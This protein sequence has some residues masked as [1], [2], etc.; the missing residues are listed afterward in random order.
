MA[1]PFMAEYGRATGD[2][3]WFDEAATQIVTIAR[4]TRD[5]ATGLYYHGW[6]ESRSQHWADP[7]SGL[8]KCFWG[9]AVGW[10][11]MG[12]VETLDAMPAN[13]PRRAEIV[14]IL[15][16]LADAIVKVQDAGSGVWY[17]VLDQGKRQGNYLESSASGMFVFALAKGARIG[18]LDATHAAAARR[19]YDGMLRQFIKQEDAGR[20]SL[21]DTCQVAGLGAG[22]RRDGT[23]E[24]Y[25][26]E[27]RVSNDPKGI[28]PF[29]LAS[30]EMEAAS[31][32]AA[33][34]PAATSPGT[35]AND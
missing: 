9:R 3:A 18:V 23:F 15:R 10:Y 16:P 33:T 27:P 17:Q 14:G 13:H 34:S 24:Y 25:I 1:C 19:G 5:D 20:I 8:S 6:D 21:S 35:R 2:G 26:S 31:A 7:K 11:A 28:A 12:I 22:Q 4:H 32:P 30:L 29:I